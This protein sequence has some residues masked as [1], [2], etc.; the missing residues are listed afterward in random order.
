MPIEAVIFDLDGTLANF[1]L[2]FK[3]LRS[4]VRSHLIRAGVPTSVL[5]V[6]ESIF[7]MLKKSEIFFKNGDK[8]NSAKVF[9]EVRSQALAI[10][11]KYEM[12]AAT[13]TSLQTGAV[14]MLK[15]LKMMK[16]KMGL[17]TTNSEKAAK[18]ILQRFKIED[19]F[20]TI[21][22]RDKVKY[23]KPH[24]EQFEL[25]LKALGARAQGTVIVGD[26]VVDMQS[27]KELKAIAVGIPTGTATLEQLKNHSANFIITSLS[28]LPAL[29]K[30]INKP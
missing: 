26:S 9:E 21:V 12:E 23:V 11:E 10:A 20:K 3:A 24:T 14:E 29:I 13:T 2:D 1:N 15:E 18:Y 17:C 30:E 27:A 7:E 5:S 8:T 19:Y 25:A 4:E 6:S 22:S 28:D 16:L